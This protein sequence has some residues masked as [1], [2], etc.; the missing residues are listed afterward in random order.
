MPTTFHWLA[1]DRQDRLAHF[2]AERWGSIPK[3]ATFLF[4]GGPGAEEL[5]S[6]LHQAWIVHIAPVRVIRVH[7]LAAIPEAKGPHLIAHDS[8]KLTRM[9]HVGRA[10]GEQLAA[11]PHVVGSVCLTREA[12]SECAHESL[13]QFSRWGDDPAYQRGALPRESLSRA[14]LTGSLE[15]LPRLEVDFSALER[16]ELDPALRFP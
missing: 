1:S 8:G 13:F 9:E 11:D 7:D 4:E 3:S 12:F 16:I 15:G 5:W 2:K 14:L 6:A 10:L